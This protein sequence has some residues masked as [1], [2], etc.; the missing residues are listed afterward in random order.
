M[1]GGRHGLAENG[2]KWPKNHKMF[3]DP[4]WQP[5]PPLRGPIRERPAA[6]GQEIWPT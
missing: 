4:R 3:G 5:P 6:A 1:V 2:L